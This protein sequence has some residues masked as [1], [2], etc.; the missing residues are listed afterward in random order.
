M[1][2]LFDAS[3]APTIPASFMNPNSSPRVRPVTHLRRPPVPPS[4]QR[5]MGCQATGRP[6]GCVGQGQSVG[7]ELGLSSGADSGAGLRHGGHRAD[8]VRLSG[9]LPRPASRHRH[10]D[11][12]ADSG[13]RLRAARG[14]GNTKGE[15]GVNP[16]WEPGPSSSLRCR[17]GIGGRKVGGIG[18]RR[19]AG[20]SLAGRIAGPPRFR[21]PRPVRPIVGDR[22]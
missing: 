17:R 1:Q 3:D 7:G 10:P 2:T 11:L 15:S 4:K 19:L 13:R 16:R 6:S 21:G 5:P 20:A 22:R 12:P 18:R 14:S 9:P 8:A